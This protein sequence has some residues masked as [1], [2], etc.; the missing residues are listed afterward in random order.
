MTGQT[1]DDYCSSIATC[2]ECGLT[3]DACVWC[4]SSDSCIASDEETLSTCDEYL[5]HGTCCPACTSLANCSSCT[6]EPGC[7]WCF[8]TGSCL[9]GDSGTFCS[10]CASYLE[11]D[12]SATALAA[13][14]VC[15]GAVDVD[16]RRVDA[17]AEAVDDFCSGRGD[18]DIETASCDCD[19]GYWGDNCTSAC[20]GG[21]SN[22]CNGQGSCDNVD[23]TC[24]C[25]CGWT[26]DDC[27][28]SSGCD[29]G[30][31]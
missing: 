14:E 22:P 17:Q 23:G 28:T 2:G 9:S 1:C 8:A 12:T 25:D 20:P 15:G 10:P 18:C 26:G 30:E 6:S 21:A 16:G 27:A 19:D 29:W 4:S 31:R 5:P 24:F 3:D 7:G 11:Y 13:C